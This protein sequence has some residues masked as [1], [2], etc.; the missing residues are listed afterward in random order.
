MV[1][2]IVLAA[3]QS[4]RMGQPKMALPWGNTTVIGQ[5][6]KTLL[7]S[8][9]EEIIVVTG[10]ARDQVEQALQESPVRFVY[11]PDYGG[12]EMIYSLQAGLAVLGEDVDAALVALGD[13]PQ[14]EL[15]VVQLVLEEFAH[16]RAALVV[17]SYQMRR[18]HPW[19]I[20]RSLWRVVLSMR[21][22]DTLRDLLSSFD[23]R[24]HYVLVGAPTILLDLDTPEDYQRYQPGKSG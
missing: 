16:T 13:H 17:P 20:S 19:V 3:G 4:K 12:G 15:A 8:G 18:G 7:Q 1:S 14:M 10:G 22:P 11:N 23:D 2:A 9:L 6:V 5:V 21:P 24:I